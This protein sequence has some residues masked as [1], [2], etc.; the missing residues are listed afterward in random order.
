MNTEKTGFF[1]ETSGVQSITRVAF[2]MMI[3]NAIFIIDYQLV[4]G[5]NIDIAAFL[6]MV[7][8]AC[9]LKLWQKSQENKSA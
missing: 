6:S 7:G 1:E 8:A 4:T 2:F 3:C 9:T 5:A